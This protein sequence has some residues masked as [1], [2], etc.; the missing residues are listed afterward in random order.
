[1]YTRT[2]ER[3]RWTSRPYE[4][5]YDN[6]SG[7]SR[8]VSHPLFGELERRQHIPEGS[9]AAAGFTLARRNVKHNGAWTEIPVA[10]MKAHDASGR[11]SGWQDW[12][13]DRNAER[14][15]GG[16]PRRTAARRD[17]AHDCPAIVGQM[18]C[19]P[20]PDGPPGVAVEGLSDYATA[21]A[22]LPS[23]TPLLGLLGATWM[24]NPQTAATLAAAAEERA[25]VVIV[26]DNDNPGRDAAEKLARRMKS[27]GAHTGV[28]VA[29]APGED[30]TDVWRRSHTPEHFK[31][32]WNAALAESL[33]HGTATLNLSTSPHIQRTPEPEPPADGAP[34]VRPIRM[35]DLGAVIA[36]R[37][38]RQWHHLRDAALLT[39]IRSGLLT[40]ADAAAVVWKDV[41]FQ[42]N[43][44]QLSLKN[45][46]ALLDRAA[47]ALIDRLL[48]APHRPAE[49]RLFGLPH[50][51]NVNMTLRRACAR[52]G[53]TA[54]RPA[55]AVRWGA[56]L[57]MASAGMTVEQIVSAGRWPNDTAVK[58]HLKR[59]RS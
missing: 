32:G 58:N 18:S 27:H 1:M 20:S 41:A 33:E 56:V 3:R 42:H 26:A 9:L 59:E 40:A 34:A 6:M 4:T 31:T 10:R 15:W 43:R 36:E 12:C 24:A 29:G 45:G 48:I 37:D 47:S 53:L 14:Y 35:P 19:W 23:G 2:P 7:R 52:A 5:T 13:S 51:D 49:G 11:Q 30:L 44:A 28:I 25:P 21:H 17:W 55:F 57:D 54:P 50:P 46:T 39:T 38:L 22:V 8:N 16:N